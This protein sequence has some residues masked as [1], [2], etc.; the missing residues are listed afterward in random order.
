MTIH[1][2]IA[3][4][5]DLGSNTFR[6]LVADCYTKKLDVQAK[7]LV[8]VGLGRGLKENGLLQ[9]DAMQTGFAVLHNFRKILDQYQPKAIR[10]CGTEALRQ[11]QNSRFFLKKAEEILQHP[12]NIITG[13][14]EARLSLAGALSGQ[15]QF[16]SFPLLLADVGGGSTEMVFAGSPAG[17]MQIA[18]I[19]L[20]VVWL[21]E[22]FIAKTRDNFDSLDNLLSENLNAFLEQL[23]PLTK[24]E[25]VCIIGSGGTATS[26]AALQLGLSSYNESLV[27]GH[28]LQH[29]AIEKLW[30]ELIALPAVKRNE[31]PCLG[32]GRGEI[33]PAGIRIFLILLKLLC[34]DRMRVSD[35]GLL[36]GILLSSITDQ[37]RYR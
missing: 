33:L 19:P 8:T 3:A 2:H 37:D 9:H 34:Q 28:V 13:E 7:K 21:T 16:F 27:H 22:R 12:V 25:P 18:S 6:L 26:M 24:N 1:Q 30:G 17:N 20:G 11:A 31:L 23:K 15:R 10:V 29:T 4:G 5:I 32:E 35:T 14:E 36:E